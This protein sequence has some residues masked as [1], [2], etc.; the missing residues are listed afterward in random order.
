MS[1]HSAIGDAKVLDRSVDVLTVSPSAGGPRRAAQTKSLRGAGCF[2]NPWMDMVGMMLVFICNPPKI[3]SFFHPNG[4][5]M[6]VKAEK[7]R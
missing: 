7:E 1:L 2:W 4:E 6:L 3:K 5:T